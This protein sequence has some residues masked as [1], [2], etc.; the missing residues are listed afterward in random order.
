MAKLT[1]TVREARDHILKRLNAL[2]S[3]D[4]ETLILE[5]LNHALVFV[6]AA[7]DWD[8]LRKKSTLTMSDA[9]GVTELPADLDRVL[10][11]HE[12]GKDQF[13]TQL[14]PL[15][16]EQERENSTITSPTYWC[17]QGYSQD[18]TSE[19]P[20]MD[21]EIIDAPSTSTVYTLWYIK[22]IDEMATADLDTVPILPPHIWDVV[23]K[24][25]MLEALKMQESPPSTIGQEER[26]LLATL[27][28]YKQRENRGSS[29][30]S[31]IMQHEAVANHF[32]T[33]MQ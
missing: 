18:T 27:Q 20:T 21:I 10:V 22:H 17:I 2:G 7:F 23:I 1:Q 30:R 12:E 3:S 11:I 19:A 25:A 28:L 33:R 5:L 13:L 8:Y 16:F 15:R 9:T 31:E 29:R 26:H 14:E 24:K 4:Y 6:S 32:A